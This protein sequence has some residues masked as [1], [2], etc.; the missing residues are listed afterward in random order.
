M[1]AI[2][3]N[4]RLRC[5]FQSS[6]TVVQVLDS[7][8]QVHAAVWFPHDLLEDLVLR[9]G[10]DRPGSTHAAEM[11]HQLR[12]AMKQHR[13]AVTEQSSRLQQHSMEE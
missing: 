2:L 1:C 8:R 13:Q 9:L 7:E 12:S 6:L 11:E 4:R 3:S 5:L 10:R